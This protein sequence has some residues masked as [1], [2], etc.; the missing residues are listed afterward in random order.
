MIEVSGSV[1]LT[2]GSGSRRPENIGTDPDPQHL[3][4]DT[5]GTDLSDMSVVVGSC[6]QPFFKKFVCTGGV[7]DPTKPSSLFLRTS[8]VFKFSRQGSTEHQ[9]VLIPGYPASSLDPD[10]LNSDSNAPLFC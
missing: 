6:C 8:F 1:L 4:T 9:N 3:Y 2:N 7:P 10:S 5:L